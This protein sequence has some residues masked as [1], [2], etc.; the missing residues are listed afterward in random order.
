MPLY[1]L[2][3]SATT[4]ATAAEYTSAWVDSGRRTSSKLN[5]VVGMIAFLRACAKFASFKHR[6]DMRMHAHGSTTVRSC[7]SAEPLDGPRAGMA[8]TFRL[9]TAGAKAGFRHKLAGTR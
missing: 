8:Q 4:G 9:S 6:H 1:P 7:T 2:S 3:T 5:S